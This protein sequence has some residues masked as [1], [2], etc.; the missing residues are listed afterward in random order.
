MKVL[1]M[2]SPAPERAGFST[3]EKKPPLGTGILISLLKG[4]GHEIAFRDEDWAPSGVLEG[5]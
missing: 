5:S 4:R 3:A 2:T 1:F